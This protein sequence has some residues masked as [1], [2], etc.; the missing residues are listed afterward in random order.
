MAE[1]TLTVE[2]RELFGK[3]NAGRIRRGG[4]IPGILYGDGKDPVPLVA[5][6]KMVDAIL[7]SPTGENTILDLELAGSGQKRPAMIHDYQR[8]P[9]KQALTHVDFVRVNME[10]KVHIRVH[11]KV[12][13]L[14]DG[15]KN[16]GGILEFVHREVHLECL[17]ADIP[18]EVTIDVTHLLI[19][20]SVRVGDLKLDPARFRILDDADTAIAVVAIP[21]AEKEET[22]A[23]TTEAATAA[24]PE[25][26]KKGKKDDEAAAGDKKPGDAKAAKADKPKAEKPK[27]DKK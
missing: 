9:I 25:V 13:G 14:A 8:H 22:V 27:A 6:P 15:V 23:A 19:G 18:R 17:P 2:R 20:Q 12:T 7:A 5:D 21:A 10:K 4:K 24:E 1:Q 26:I 16:Q 3:N 11:L